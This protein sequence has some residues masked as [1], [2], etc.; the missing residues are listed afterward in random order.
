MM[1][2]TLVVPGQTE[3]MILG[4]NAIKRLLMQSRET[5]GY[6][7]LMAKSSNDESAECSISISFL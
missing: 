5:N 2:P 3:E 1:I 6:W 4:T 7:K